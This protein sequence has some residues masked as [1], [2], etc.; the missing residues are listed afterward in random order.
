MSRTCS[1]PSVVAPLLGS[2]PPA[3][4][5]TCGDRANKFLQLLAYLRDFSFGSSRVMTMGPEAMKHTFTLGHEALSPLFHHAGGR[6]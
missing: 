3:V 2:W 6:W 1:G 5:R 4:I